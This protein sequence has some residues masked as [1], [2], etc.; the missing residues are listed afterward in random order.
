VLG[1]ADGTHC[2]PGRSRNRQTRGRI[3][4]PNAESGS[5]CR[6]RF[7]GAYLV[8]A[9]RDFAASPRRSSFERGQSVMCRNAWR[10]A[11]VRS[12]P[13]RLP[14]IDARRGARPGASRACARS[15]RRCASPVRHRL[16]GGG[17]RPAAPTAHAV[18]TQKSAAAVSSGVRV[19][20]GSRRCWQLV[21]QPAKVFEHPVVLGTKSSVRGFI[22]FGAA[23]SRPAHDRAR[24]A[25][26]SARR[27]PR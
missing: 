18:A 6:G 25:D 23:Q 5:A 22:A 13:S 7:D 10:R 16:T 1:T 8:H 15:M 4:L 26:S 24:P 27:Q 17:L 3:S 19:E 12:P 20:C 2:G 11:V 14:Q 21:V 9:R